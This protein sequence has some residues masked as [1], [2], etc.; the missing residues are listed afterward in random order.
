[1]SCF[2]NYV[3]QLHVRLLDELDELIES[4]RRSLRD[5]R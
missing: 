4:K 3:S 5:P 1:L 2:V